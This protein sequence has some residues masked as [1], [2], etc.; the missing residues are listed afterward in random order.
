[1]F[2]ELLRTGKF[3]G[4]KI[5]EKMIND[6]EFTFP[7]NV[8]ISLGHDQQSP[9]MMDNVPAQGYVTSLDR[10]K[11]SNLHGKIE[12]N[13]EGQENWDSG[14]YRNWSVGLRKGDTGIEGATK[15]TWQLDHVAM[16]GARSPA[17]PNLE[18]IN[19]SKSSNEEFMYIT[20][21]DGEIDIINLSQGTNKKDDTMDPK[22]IIAELEAK[23]KG[24][25]G[26]IDELKL[27]V[28]TE[29]TLNINLSSKVKELEKPE[30]S[31]TDDPKIIELR[32]EV[33]ELK[34]KRLDD[35]KSNFKSQHSTDF[36]E[37]KLNSFLENAT[38]ESLNNFSNLLGGIIKKEIPALGR[39]KFVKTE[40]PR[41][42]KPVRIPM[43]FDKRG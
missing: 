41:D 23:I 39:T 37:A 36:E 10:K 43:G 16:L 3:N 8:P 24:L 6:L 34:T 25:E 38:L 42:N 27:S 4:N 26:E 33:E 30:E 2:W 22:K 7:G 14:R 1:M 32:K 11:P 19:N 15:N 35:A 20:N 29:K 5:T 28:E 17:I 12:F 13:Q 31:P 18:I 40:Q 21:I 9:F